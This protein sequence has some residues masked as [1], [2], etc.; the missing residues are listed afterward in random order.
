LVD[1]ADVAQT[2]LKA[3]VP[4][5]GTAERSAMI[6]MLTSG[7][8]KLAGIAAGSTAVGVPLAATAAGLAG[9]AMATKAY[10][11]PRVQNFYEGLNITDPLMNYLASPVDPMLRYAAT[12]NLLN[13]APEPYRIDI[14]GVGQTQ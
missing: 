1:L 3:K 4:T 11:S 14:T 5:S 7:P 12:P 10:L 2:S 9:P 8:A 6:N 13:I